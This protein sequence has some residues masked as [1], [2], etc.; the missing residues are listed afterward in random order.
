MLVALLP[1]KNAFAQQNNIWY[2]GSGAGIAFNSN[3]SGTVPYSFGGNAMKTTEGCASICNASGNLLFYSNGA[4]VYNNKNEIMLNGNGLAGNISAF[5]SV[6]ILAQPGSDS[7]YYVFTADAFENNFAKGYNYSIIDMSR[8]SG[9]GEVITKNV[10]LNAPGTERLAAARHANGTDIWII[11]NDYNSN[12]FRNWL[13]TCTG[14]EPS[15]TIS[16]VGE[17]MNKDRYNNTGSLKVS[18]DGNLLCQTHF[19]DIDSNASNFFQ[20]FD[21]DNSTGIVSNPNLVSISGSYH[22]TC[23][24]SPNSKLLYV[25]NA[26]QEEINQ[27]NVSINNAAAIA[28]SRYSITALKNFYGIQT[29]PDKKIYLNRSSDKLGVISNPDVSGAGCNFIIE[30]I[31]L[32]GKDGELG[33]PTTIN[34]LYG[35]DYNDFTY[36]IVDTCSARVQFFGQTSISGAV[37]WEWDFGEG[38]GSNLQNPEHQFPS[39]NKSYSVVLKVRSAGNCGYF[40]KG[41]NII[42]GGILAKADFSYLVDCDSGQVQFTNQSTVSDSSLIYYL[43]NFNDQTTSSSSNPLHSFPQSQ[44]YQVQLN[45]FTP[46]ACLNDSVGYRVNAVPFVIKALP[47]KTVDEGTPVQLYVSGAVTGIQWSPPQWLNN[48]NIPNPVATPFQ[49]ISYTVTA[50]NSAGCIAIDSVIIKVIEVNDIYVPTGFTPNSDG[51]NDLLR[52]YYG[53]KYILQKFSVF[54]RLGAR[55]FETANKGAGW[56][57][58][59][60]NQAQ[61]GGVYVW[62]LQA[63]DLQ[64]KP[65]LKRGTTMLIR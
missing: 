60:K 37:E 62:I 24:F 29:G 12:V 4:T 18:P 44:S 49:D 53:S 6:V 27:F 48:I 51:I 13:I 41:Y 35:L 7:L 52:P 42:P 31:D 9:Y 17:V 34:D 54:N 46:K 33:L 19:P 43:W 63:I 56:D 64:G 57:G 3:G 58:T 2:F 23:E 30:A 47:G 1:V 50:V 22:N 8:D 11:T 20:V 55:I 45:L 16:T 26:R 21:F 25:T 38:S 15:P 5:Q 40:E 59:Y 61:N 28:A 10:L 39:P 14:I 65:M 36:R 32:N